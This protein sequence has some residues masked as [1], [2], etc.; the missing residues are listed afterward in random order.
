M[1]SFNAFIHKVLETC[2]NANFLISVKNFIISTD[3]DIF[4]EIFVKL[5]Y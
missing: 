4:F 5:E 3:I 2:F 1:H